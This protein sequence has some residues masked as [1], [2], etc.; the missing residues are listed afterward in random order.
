MLLP[1]KPDFVRALVARQGNKP[2]PHLK[3][4]N[5]VIDGGWLLFRVP[6][7]SCGISIAQIIGLYIA[8]VNRHF[9]ASSATC[10]TIVFDGYLSQG[11]PKNS[12]HC[13]RVVVKQ[14]QRLTLILN[15]QLT[16][17]KD[18]FLSKSFSS[19]VMNAAYYLKH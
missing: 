8:Y 18:L 3:V 13:Q 9:P 11:P 12:T 4:S 7:W 1:N 2:I 14:D 16:L 15:T 5:Y 6:K 19:W 17:S 10:S